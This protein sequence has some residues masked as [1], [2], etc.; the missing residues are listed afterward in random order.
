MLKKLKQALQRLLQP[1]TMENLPEAVMALPK[2]AREIWHAA[3]NAAYEQYDGDEE[4]AMATAWAAVKQKYEEKDGTWTLKQAAGEIGNEEL[5]SMICDALAR[6]FPWPGGGSG[7]THSLMEVYS[8]RC[9]TQD[10]DGHLFE[11]AYSIEAGAVVLSPEIKSVEPQVSYITQQAAPSSVQ[12][13]DAEG[14][15]WEVV[16]IEAG[17]SK[18]GYN[19]FPQSTLEQ[20]LPI[21]EGS[22]AFA[23]SAGQHVDDALK[24]PVKDIIGWYDQIRMSGT[25]IVA[26][27]HLLQTADWLRQMLMDA[28]K[29]GKKDLLGLSVDLVGASAIQQIDGRKGRVWTKFVKS[30]GTDV[31]WDPAGGGAFVKLLATQQI[32]PTL[33]GGQKKEEE[34][35]QKLLELLQARRPDLYAKIDPVKITEDELLTHLRAAMPEAAAAGNQKTTD[36][37]LQKILQ[38]DARIR[39]REQLAESNLPELAQARI[40][41]R[42]EGQVFEDAALQQ[43]IK[44]EQEYLGKLT[45]S[46]KPTGFGDGHVEVEGQTERV[47][48]SLHKM[49]F[50]SVDPKMIPEDIRK[51]DSAPFTSIRQAY[52]R[53]TGDTDIRGFVDAAKMRLQQAISSATFANLFA[54][55]LYRRLIADY[56]AQDYGERNIITVGNAPDFRTREAVRIGYF[57]DLSTVD[58]ETGDYQELAAP[59]DEKVSYA[60]GQKGNIITI[61]RKAIINDDLRG[62]DKIVGRAGRSAR[63]TFARFVWNFAINNSTYDAD[64]LAWFHATHANLQSTALAAAEVQATVLKLQNMTEPGSGEKL[65]LNFSRGLENLGLWLAAPTALWDVAKQTNERQYLDAN[66]TPNPVQYIFGRNSERIIVNPLFADANDWYVFR[67][68]RDVESIG[69]DFLGGQEEPELFLADQPTVGQ[70]FVADKLQYKIRHEYGGDIIDYRGAV[71]AAVA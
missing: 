71:K 12:P 69:I 32:N 42:Y 68:P 6:R 16:L 45:E 17:W 59:S 52:V 22:K 54:N 56:N 63:R 3:F 64:A 62:I 40:K 28:W 55:T 58:P 39:L 51:S 47:Q 23:L 11:I 10:P 14:N 29:K 53:I 37:T 21:F 41:K 1:Y 4:K 57:G 31:V 20:A 65:G 60:V 49:L 61:T 46:G 5:R 33:G 26:R 38:A 36:E 7:S 30:N 15:E 43:A 24:K 48:M 13:V 2:A 67:D 9:I 34:M 44:D 27:L 25:K 35:K 19:Y 8:D 50:R 70:M 66:F 18:D